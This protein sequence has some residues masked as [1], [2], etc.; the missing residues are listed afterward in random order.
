[1]DQGESELEQLILFL[2]LLHRPVTIGPFFDDGS[3]PGYQIQQEPYFR[4]SSDVLIVEE[5]RLMN[6]LI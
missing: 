5:Y 6:P 2:A 1:M 3:D 4:S